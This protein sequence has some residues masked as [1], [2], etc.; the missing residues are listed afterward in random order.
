MKQAGKP[1]A[2]R[3]SKK[4]MLCAFCRAYKKGTAHANLP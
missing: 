1:K 2:D 4:A 3:A